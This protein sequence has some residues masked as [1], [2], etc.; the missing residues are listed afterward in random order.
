MDRDYWPSTMNDVDYLFNLLAAADDG[1][2]WRALRDM[3]PVVD[4]ET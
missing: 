2:D 3:R 4:V 1:L